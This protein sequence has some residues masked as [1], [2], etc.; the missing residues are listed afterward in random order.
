MSKRS[1]TSTS[2]VAVLFC[3]AALLPEV[4]SANVLDNFG[5][6]ILGILNS[7]FLR[8]IAIAAI[9]VAGLLALSGRIQWLAFITVLFAVVIVFG[10]AGIVDYIVDNAATASLELPVSATSNVA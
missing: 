4:A 1:L 10:A 5:Q 7:G 3:A 6:A 2:G 8:A 9:I